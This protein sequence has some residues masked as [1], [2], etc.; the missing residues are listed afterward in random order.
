VSRDV[1][2]AAAATSPQL[3]Q[4]APSSGEVIASA[5]VGDAVPVTLALTLNQEHA[6][7]A[8]ERAIID[9]DLS[10]STTIE[11]PVHI[12]TERIAATNATAYLFPST[13]ITEPAGRGMN[14]LDL[15]SGLEIWGADGAS[16]LFPFV[17]DAKVHRD[18][19][20]LYSVNGG[21]LGIVWLGEPRPVGDAFSFL[22]GYEDPTGPE[23]NPRISAH[24][25]WLSRDGNRLYLEQPHVYDLHPGFDDD[26]HYRGLVEWAYR[27]TAM[28]DHPDT[29]TLVAVMHDYWWYPEP[30]EPRR[31]ESERS[32]RVYDRDTL[33]L[34]HTI[35]L[36]PFVDDGQ[37]RSAYGEHVFINQDGSRAYVVAATHDAQP[38]AGIAVLDLTANPPTWLP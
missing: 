7:I 11:A 34:R 35:E 16:K 19:N 13:R 32:V 15:K 17:A 14:I 24:R 10:T 33:E 37:E 27:I 21:Y 3:V 25:L 12:R 36:P 30:G 5:T 6:L 9:V 23:T 4:I 31:I 29:G 28:D 1:I 20:Y 26:L 18:G 22:T 38:R 8:T 2:V